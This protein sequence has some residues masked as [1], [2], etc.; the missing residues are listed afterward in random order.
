METKEL[1]NKQDKE[2]KELIKTGTFE[3]IKNFQCKNCKN[4]N[5]A[6][7][8]GCDGLA[9]L[10][11][12]LEAGEDVFGKLAEIKEEIEKES[13]SYGEIA[14]LQD[15]KQEVLDT[16]DIL[17]CQWAGIS[18]DEYNN[19]ILFDDKYMVGR[20]I[21]LRNVTED[22]DLND[23]TGTYGDEVVI[24]SIEGAYFWGVNMEHKVVVPYH[25]EYKDIIEFTPFE[26]PN[27]QYN[28]GEFEN[29]EKCKYCEEFFT[30]DE[31]NNKGN[32]EN[33]QFTIDERD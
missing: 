22:N 16:G 9:W 23:F 11:N 20:K 15:H 8:T 26:Y 32:C 17:L 30:P 25:M 18:E 14:Y 27:I 4:C 29:V 3:Q 13:V 1:C 10:D 2:I 19:G 6:S 12:I 24:T 7:E 5:V 31:L 33:C 21:V 28:L